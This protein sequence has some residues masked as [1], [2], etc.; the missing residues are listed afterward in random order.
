MSEHPQ[1]PPNCPEFIE[2]P[3]GWHFSVRGLDIMNSSCVCVRVG[4]AVPVW[5]RIIAAVGEVACRK[6][7][8]RL[9]PAI[10]KAAQNWYPGGEEYNRLRVEEVGWR[11]SVRAWR[12]WGEQA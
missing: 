8:D 9:I 10:R 7:A 1:A 4:E 11:R 6:E 2:M 12:T 3:D 5:R